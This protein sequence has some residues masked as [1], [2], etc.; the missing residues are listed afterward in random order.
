MKLDWSHTVLNIKDKDKILD[1]YTKT[2]GFKVS[3][4]GPIYKDGPEIIFVS[5]NTHNIEYTVNLWESDSQ[6][7]IAHHKH[8]LDVGA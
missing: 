6:N 5:W 8:G 3:D 2:L 7:T 4:S 1:F